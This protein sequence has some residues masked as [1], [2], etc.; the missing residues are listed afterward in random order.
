[1]AQKVEKYYSMKK[2]SNKSKVAMAI[3]AHPD[4]IEFGCGG[5]LLKHVKEGY[6]IIYVCMTGSESIDGTVKG[7][8]IIRSS[9]QLHDELKEACKRLKVTKYYI[10][11]NI[12][13]HLEFNFENISALEK[14]IKRHKPSIIYTHWAGDANQDHI[15]TFKI[16]MAAARYVPNVLCYEQIPI[17]RLSENNMDAHYYVDISDTFDDKIKASLAHKSQIDKYRNIGLDVVSNLAILA[18]YRGI[19]AGC[20][21]AEVFQVIKMVK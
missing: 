5:T 21:A 17:A 19:Q 1:M 6:E 12:D 18:Q 4:D 15:A 11:D 2:K 8:K 14:L 16:T 3:G 20:D 13:L 9:K 7:E 10:L